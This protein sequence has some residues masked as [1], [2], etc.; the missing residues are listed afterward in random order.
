MKEFGRIKM[1]EINHR[2]RPPTPRRLRA[3]RLASLMLAMFGL[4]SAAVAA[5]IPGVQTSLLPDGLAVR[6][7]GAKFAVDKAGKVKLLKDKS[8]IDPAGLG[9][10]PSG[11]KLTY[12]IKNCTFKGSFNAYT[13]SGGTLK[14]V[15]VN[16]S[17][18]VLGGRG[19]G[20]ASVKKTG[21]VP[22]VI[23]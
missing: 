3:G 19:Y 4:T 18:V 7:E 8:G 1:M 5:A 9:T 23:E 22:V 21:S 15:K 14:K 17:G 13:L 10:N 11:L 6:M 12:I 2:L 20:T 16:V